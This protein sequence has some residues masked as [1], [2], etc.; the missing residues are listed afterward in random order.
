M[1][2]RNQLP[3]SVRFLF[4]LLA[5]VFFGAQG[6]A[7]TDGVRCESLFKS[8]T[9]LEERLQIIEN[10][11][12]LELSEMLFQMN[13][14]KKL[15]YRGNHQFEPGTEFLASNEF[16]W[17]GTPFDHKPADTLVAF[18]TNSAWEIAV[19]KNVKSMYIADWSPYPLLASAYIVSPLIKIAKSPKE[20]I[21]LLSGRIP[22]KKLLQESLDETFYHA[23]QYSLFLTPE[24]LTETKSFLSFLARQAISD[25]ELKFLTSYFLG[26]AGQNAGPQSLGPFVNLRYA[27]YA[28][29]LNFYDQRYGPS[30]VEE[31][32]RDVVKKTTLKRA[33]V[34]SSPINFQRLRRL[35]LKDQV[36]YG[37]TS[38]TDMKFYEAVRRKEQ[39]LGRMSYVISISNIFDC[40]HYNGL[41]HLDLQ[42]F[43]LGVT[44]IFGATSKSPLVVFRTSNTH[45][46][47]EFHRYDLT[48]QEQVYNIQPE[49]P[50]PQAQ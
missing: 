25:F 29:L 10:P 1:A 44:Q 35:F 50:L 27:S 15:V 21:I 45:P 28:R 17:L 47:H 49:M 38:I 46:P 34:F 20:F 42:N 19:D 32:N 40:T 33:S 7:T 24:K 5:F 23:R 39:M 41:T 36:H 2:N 22:T 14:E 12:S 3:T 8:P 37:L 11:V 30:V 16:D 13:T 6:Y 26:L 4:L 18:G 9:A 31:A 43:L 48:G